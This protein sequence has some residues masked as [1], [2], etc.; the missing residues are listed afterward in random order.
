MRGLARFG[1]AVAELTWLIWFGLLVWKL[2]RSG[3]KWTLRHM[4]RAAT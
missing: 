1:S 3:W 4:A 2:T